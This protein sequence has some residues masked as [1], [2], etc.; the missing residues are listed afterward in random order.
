MNAV[1]ALAISPLRHFGVV[2]IRLTN[3]SSFIASSRR[4]GYK[5]TREE[6]GTGVWISWSGRSAGG[7][8]PTVVFHS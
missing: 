4:C 1:A 2:D 3:A 7:L 5:V 8:S 6:V